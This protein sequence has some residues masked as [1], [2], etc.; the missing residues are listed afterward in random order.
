[1]NKDKEIKTITASEDV[2]KFY[3]LAINFCPICNNKID[4]NT[5]IAKL[6][7]VAYHMECYFNSTSDSFKIK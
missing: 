2:Q 4:C 5:G 7:S 1:M 3:D 6:G